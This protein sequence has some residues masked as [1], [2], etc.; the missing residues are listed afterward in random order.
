M[1]SGVQVSPGCAARAARRAPRVDA[2]WEDLREGKEPRAQA[3][4]E[5]PRPWPGQG[6]KQ[7]RTPQAPVQAS[8]ERPEAPMVP[9]PVAWEV[10]RREGRVQGRPEEATAQPRVAPEPAEPRE[11]WELGPPEEVMM[12]VPGAPDSALRAER[13]V[14]EQKESPTS[15]SSEPWA[16]EWEQREA[17]EQEVVLREQPVQAR[18]PAQ[19][20][21]QWAAG[22]PDGPARGEEPL[23]EASV[24]SGPK[25]E[26]GKAERVAASPDPKE[27]V[28]SGPL[29][30]PECRPATEPLCARCPPAP[31]Q[32]LH[33]AEPPCGR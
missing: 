10:A 1:R 32:A 17:W 25:R 20:R 15:A 16:P 5:P 18:P 23:P 19:A 21:R 31:S 14:K 33:R 4:G 28:G 12:Q 9:V 24:H 29:P 22:S 3:R 30:E 26:Q 6:A 27:A 2:C 11:G 13:P 7:A 8:L